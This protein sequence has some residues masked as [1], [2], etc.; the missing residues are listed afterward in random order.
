[1]RRRLTLRLKKKARPALKLRAFNARSPLP[2]YDFA[3]Y[4][5]FIIL[6]SRGNI[7]RQNKIFRACQVKP[8]AFPSFLGQMTF[9]LIAKIRI[10]IT[11]CNCQAIAGENGLSKGNQSRVMLFSAWIHLIREF[12]TFLMWC[13]SS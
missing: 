13:H 4:G 8:D 9:T 2:S 11:E 5:R 10:L 12:S 1:M 3:T 7:T 6:E